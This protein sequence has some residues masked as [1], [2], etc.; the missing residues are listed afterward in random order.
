MKEWHRRN[1]TKTAFVDF[2]WDSL[3]VF[4][5]RIERLSKRVNKATFDVHTIFFGQKNSMQRALGM[6]H[7]AKKKAPAYC[8]GSVLL[9]TLQG[10]DV[11]RA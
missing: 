4:F 9:Y 7:A 10:L 8:R 6:G 1:N 11:Y 3:T 2:P 5:Q